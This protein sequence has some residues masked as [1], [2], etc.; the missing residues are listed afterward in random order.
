LKRRCRHFFCGW[1]EEAE[2]R[3]ADRI[4]SLVSGVASVVFIPSI[5]P[6]DDDTVYLVEDDYGPI[7]RCWRETE[8]ERSSRASVIEDLKRGEFHNPVRVV[9]FNSREGWAQDVSHEIAVEVQRLADLTGDELPGTVATFVEEHTRP[10]R[11]LTLR[12]A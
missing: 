1:S 12:L 9:A 10:A 5:V 4:D 3:N 2:R 6:Q 8:A 7:G 11:Q